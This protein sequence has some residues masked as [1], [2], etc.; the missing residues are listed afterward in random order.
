MTPEHP[1][2]PEDNKSTTAHV[3]DSRQPEKAHHGDTAL[4]I[5]TQIGGQHGDIDPAETR[6]LVRKIDYMILPFLSICYAFYY[7]RTSSGLEMSDN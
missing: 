5:L 3:E 6:R 1:P 4:A 7:V 2:I